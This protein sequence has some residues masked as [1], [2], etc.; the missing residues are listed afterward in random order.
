[1]LLAI[2]GLPHAFC[3]LGSATDKDC[4]GSIGGKLPLLFA[5]PNNSPAAEELGISVDLMGGDGE[6]NG[7]DRG[8]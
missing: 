8:H 5:A 1:M 3:A 2:K 6:D 7:L 4:E